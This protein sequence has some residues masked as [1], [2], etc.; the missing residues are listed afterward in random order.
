M[1]FDVA[2]IVQD[3]IEEPDVQTDEAGVSS[4]Y[5]EVVLDEPY[6][7]LPG[8]TLGKVKEHLADIYRCY[9]RGG[10]LV[11]KVNGQALSYEEPEILNAPF[12]REPR[13]EPVLWRKH[14]A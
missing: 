5:T 13:G 9:L 7:P 3:N 8:R 11:L 10:S 1:R 4:H 12:Y 14:R 6:S 2:R